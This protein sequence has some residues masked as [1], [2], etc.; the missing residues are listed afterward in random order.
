MSS[1]LSQFKN[2]FT[3]EKCK[4]QVVR[5]EKGCRGHTLD[6]KGVKKEEQIEAG[7]RGL[8]HKLLSKGVNQAVRQSVSSRAAWR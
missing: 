2:L 6:I 7:S 5:K 4:I 3:A 1:F 8:R